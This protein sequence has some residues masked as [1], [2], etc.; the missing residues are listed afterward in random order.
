MALRQTL[1]H[2][3]FVIAWACAVLAALFALT[4]AMERAQAGGDATTSGF[5]PDAIFCLL[6]YF[7]RNQ[8]RQWRMI[9]FRITLEAARLSRP[10]LAAS[11]R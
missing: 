11:A 3:R 9:C 2:V 6:H 8:R 5:L 1:S 10:S 7:L 4:I